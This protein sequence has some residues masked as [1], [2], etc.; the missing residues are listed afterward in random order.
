[1]PA[2]QATLDAE[3]AEKARLQE[4]I[5]AL[6]RDLAGLRVTVSSVSRAAGMID[7]AQVTGLKNQISTL[8]RQRAAADVTIRDLTERYETA[9][10]VVEARYE[11]DS[12]EPWTPEELLRQAREQN[13][14]LELRVAELQAANESLETWRKPVAS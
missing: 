5:A 12:P 3:R 10:A 11:V 1:M 13:A 4:E 6:R 14:A 2:R 8:E 9:M 7:S